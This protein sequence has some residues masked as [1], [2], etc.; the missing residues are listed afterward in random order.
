MKSIGSGLLL[1]LLTHPLTAADLQKGDLVLLSGVSCG[2]PGVTCNGILF[3]DIHDVAG[4]YRRTATVDREPTFIANDVV[5]EGAVRAVV[6]PSPRLRRLNANGSIGEPFGPRFLFAGGMTTDAK[7]TIWLDAGDVPGVPELIHLDLSGNVLARLSVPGL[8]S[9]FDLAADQC[10]LYY[11][12][13]DWVNLPPPGIETLARFDVCSGRALPDLPLQWSWEDWAPRLR[14]VPDGLLL[15]HWKHI[16]RVSFDGK[17]TLTQR[18]QGGDFSALVGLAIEPSGETFW[19]SDGITSE[20]FD[21]NTLRRI[22]EASTGTTAEGLHSMKAM[23][24]VDGWRAARGDR[25]REGV[26]WRPK[27]P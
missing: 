4:Q 15:V 26:P 8:T 24:I 21:V 3:V 25:T 18:H 5:A 1:L 13:Y 20:H 11:V 17:V 9:A 14:V 2:S 7:G 23:T 12:R 27:A 6:G 22:G 16:D 10:T 19:V